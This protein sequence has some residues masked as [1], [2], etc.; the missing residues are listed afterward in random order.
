MF[1]SSHRMKTRLEEQAE[2]PEDV[3]GSTSTRQ[4]LMVADR[5]ASLRASMGLLRS[6]TISFCNRTGNCLVRGNDEVEP[7]ILPIAVSGLP[8]MFT[9]VTRSAPMSRTLA[10]LQAT[11]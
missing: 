7:I 8:T 2:L 1:P 4:Q 9:L 6:A 5:Q 11:S 3:G 10:I